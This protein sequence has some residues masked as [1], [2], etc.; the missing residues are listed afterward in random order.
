MTPPDQAGA[1]SA[2]ASSREARPLRTAGA[3]SVP[4]FLSAKDLA[5]GDKLFFG[6]AR[7]VRRALGALAVTAVAALIA[8]AVARAF[9]YAVPADALVIAG[10]AAVA[11]SVIWFFAALLR[12]HPARV[13]F[14]RANAKHGAG[15][16]T[17]ELRPYGHVIGCRTGKQPAK[18]HNVASTL[19]GRTMLNLRALFSDH[20]TLALD[21]SADVAALL[22][23]CSDA[24]IVD[25]SDG[26][27]ENWSAI[28]PEA[29]RCVFVS[30]WGQ[31][32]RAEAAFAALGLPGQCFFY[33]PDGEIQRRSQFRAA[34]L[35]A[36][37]A[38]HP[39]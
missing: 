14:M 1:G 13:C 32:E 7:A 23:G 9:G 21:G 24:L 27:P 38:A 33:A 30:A 3:P 11:L 25:L 26:A 18:S 8:A 20:E 12:A 5:R 31:H 10:M 35:A 2:A 16:F 6:P 34:M 22:A 39:A 15:R 37:R 29:A 4:S 36:M 17:R 28:Q 19:R